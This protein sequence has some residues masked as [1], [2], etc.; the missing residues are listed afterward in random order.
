MKKITLFV[1]LFAFAVV[2]A[3]KDDKTTDKLSFKKGTQF[4]N[5]NLS[6]NTSSSELDAQTQNQESKN[7]GLSINPSY[8]YAISDDFFLGL[9]LGYGTN[10]R[11]NELNGVMESEASTNS[12]AVFPYVRYYKGIGKKLAFFLHGETRYTYSKN[13]VN[14]TN[15]RTT[16]SFFFGVRPGFVFMLNKNLGLETSI[17]ALGYTTSNV[18]DEGNNSESDFNS[19]N[20]SLNSSNLLVGLSYYF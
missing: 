20:F 6:L 7:F 17:G 12:F 5:L 13:E 3:Q 8:S 14:N 19:F 11:E 15:P 16:N 10:T 18:E 1:F 9:G 4:I 2:S